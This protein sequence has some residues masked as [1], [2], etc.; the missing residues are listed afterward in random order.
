MSRG[1]VLMELDSLSTDSIVTLWKHDS[2]DWLVPTVHIRV[3]WLLQWVARMHLSSFT[4]FVRMQISWCGING[5]AFVWLMLQM[6]RADITILA[7]QLVHLTSTY[8]ILQKSIQRAWQSRGYLRTLA[9]QVV[10]S[11]FNGCYSERQEGTFQVSI[12]L[13]EDIV[14]RQD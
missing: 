11:E 9:A 6:R 14:L 8:D 3:W 2:M 7:A 4:S 1:L 12:L 10:P 13:E 5:Q